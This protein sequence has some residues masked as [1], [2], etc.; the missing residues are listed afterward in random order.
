M[1][2]EFEGVSKSVNFTEPQ[3][4]IMK[5]LN[6]GERT[7]MINTHY[8]SGGEF[9]W[10]NRLEEFGCKEMVGYRAFNGAMFAIRKAFQL[11]RAAESRLYAKY[12]N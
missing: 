8:V 4:E 6:R 2:V 9:V 11:D 7:T 5:R 3:A 10:K 12:I 1:T